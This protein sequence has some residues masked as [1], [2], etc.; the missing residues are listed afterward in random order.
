MDFSSNKNWFKPIEELTFADDFIFAKV[1]ENKEI[2]KQVLELLMG[3]KIGDIKYPKLQEVLN[4]CYDNKS[5][6]LD[7]FAEDGVRVFNI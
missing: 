3:I 1:M 5:I 7:V 6:R 4:Q 2:C